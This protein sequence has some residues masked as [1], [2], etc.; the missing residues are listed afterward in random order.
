MPKQPRKYIYPKD[1]TEHTNLKWQIAVTFSLGVLISLSETLQTWFALQAIG[2]QLA[3]SVVLIIIFY[4]FFILS[5]KKLLSLNYYGDTELEI[6]SNQIVLGSK[7]KAKVNLDGHFQAGDIFDIELKN[8]YT[9]HIKETFYGENTTSD[10]TKI[11]WEQSY[12][13]KVIQEEKETYL[14]F[15]FDLDVEEEQVETKT[16]HDDSHYNWELNIHSTAGKYN[17]YRTYLLVV[18]AKKQ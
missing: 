8:I 15:T 3:I 5:I 10:K 18:G 6:L 9:Y 13:T 1:I 4:I 11:I 14:T 17:L 12:K 2:T 16:L 7:L